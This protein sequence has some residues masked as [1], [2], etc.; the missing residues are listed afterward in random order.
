MWRRGICTSVSTSGGP[1]TAGMKCGSAGNTVRSLR[2]ESR[3]LPHLSRIIKRTTNKSASAVVKSPSAVVES[4]SAVVESSDGPPHPRANG[5][6]L[7]SECLRLAQYWFVSKKITP[8]NLLGPQW[9]FRGWFSKHYT[10]PLMQL[11]R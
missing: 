3:T 4:A 11:L 5:N 7:I 8:P 10:L 1:W 6:H 2:R 9:T